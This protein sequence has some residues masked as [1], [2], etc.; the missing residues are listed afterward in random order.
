MTHLMKSCKAVINV[1]SGGCERLST[2]LAGVF[3][4]LMVVFL[5]R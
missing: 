5:G 4:L 3:L 1:K 2:L